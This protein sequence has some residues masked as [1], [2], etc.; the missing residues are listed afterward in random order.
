MGIG[1]GKVN[2]RLRDWLISRQRYWAAPFRL[3]TA[4]TAAMYWYRKKI[5]LSNF[6]Q[7]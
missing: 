7:M 5:C 6:L 4:L 1:R 2:Y 3:S